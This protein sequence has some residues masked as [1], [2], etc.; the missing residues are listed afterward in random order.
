MKLKKSIIKLYKK[1]P[2]WVKKDLI[3]TGGTGWLYT[4]NKILGWDWVSDS[5]HLQIEYSDSNFIPTESYAYLEYIKDLL[6]PLSEEIDVIVKEDDKNM[7]IGFNIINRNEEAEEILGSGSNRLSAMLNLLDNISDFYWNNHCPSLNDVNAEDSIGFTFQDLKADIEVFEDKSGKYS[8]TF[9]NHHAANNF[10]DKF[11]R[12]V[13]STPEC[14]NGDYSSESYHG[15]MN[16]VEGITEIYSNYGKEYDPEYYKARPA[17]P[18]STIVGG[19]S[20]VISGAQVSLP[21]TM[22]AVCSSG[23]GSHL[24][25]KG[26]FSN[27]I[28]GNAVG[29]MLANNMT[30]A[31]KPLTI[32]ASKAVA[33]TRGF[34][35]SIV[36][37]DE[38]GFF[39]SGNKHVDASKAIVRYKK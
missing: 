9:S 37:L 3:D 10:M 30:G 2:E 8:I 7:I 12:F 11:R 28:G 14:Q 26:A 36:S 24:T 35:S 39:D 6:L 17:G 21:L 4:G 13:D 22:G 18:Y 5:K 23:T 34:S 15:T 31:M 16:M 38:P 27:A 20:S 32:A 25:I 19:T 1:L 29:T 33:A